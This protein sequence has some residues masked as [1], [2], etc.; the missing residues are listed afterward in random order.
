[1]KSYE[2]GCNFSPLNNIGEKEVVEVI[3]NG[4]IVLNLINY[5]LNS[6]STFNKMGRYF[7]E[8]EEML[9]VFIMYIHDLIVYN[10]FIK[11]IVDLSLNQLVSS[12]TPETMKHHYLF[13][14]EAQK[15]SDRLYEF[16]YNRYYYRRV[17]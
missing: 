6:Q 16:F 11:N 10:K 17:R 13:I 8:R 1:M 14:T 15:T 5:I 9:N 3:N 12:C 7:P 2:F 4:F